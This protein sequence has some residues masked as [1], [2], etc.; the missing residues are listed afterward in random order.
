MSLCYKCRGRLWC[1]KPKCPLLLKK[2]EIQKISLKKEFSSITPPNVFIGSYNY[3]KINAG[4]LCIP[5]IQ[6]AESYD[7]V[8]SWMD[9]KLKIDEIV[10]RRS[11]VFNTKK[12]IDIKD[13]SSKF[14]LDFIQPIALSS[15][16]LELEI[17]LKNIPKISVSFDSE[18]KPMGPSIELESAKITENVKINTAVE[19]VYY[20]TDLPAV[21]A[22]N[23]LDK[24][25]LDVYHL[26]RLM[27]AGTL[28]IKRKL[29][30]TKWAIT[31]VDDSL[32]IQKIEDVKNFP[33]IDKFQLFYGG[34]YG[35]RFAVILLP[36]NWCFEL[37]EFNLKGSLW[38]K[39][40]TGYT[41]DFEF[42][43]GRKEYSFECSGGYYA[44]RLPVLEYLEK[45]KKQAGVLIIRQISSEYWL[46]LGVWVVRE[47]VKKALNSKFKI[48]ESKEQVFSYL[49]QLLDIDF[50][51]IQK[52]SRVLNQTII[53][54]FM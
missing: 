28:G 49:K 15:K 33:L 38:A 27:S 43:N 45:I 21:E 12:D 34:H 40:E 16:Q 6:N 37:F 35:N 1:K 30:P 10:R 5:S 11:I 31:A 3:P 20:Q 2:Y 23:F 48:F 8:K 24:N 9:E 36:K 29:I 25:N 41:H 32:G 19:K 7:N 47:A 14:I 51:I 44:S 50:R 4:S 13:S 53:Q 18:N 26:S 54:D 52:E 17:K 46:P 42:Y 22:I 39:E